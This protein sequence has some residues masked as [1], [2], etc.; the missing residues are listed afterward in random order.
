MSTATRA[1]TAT[2]RERVLWPAAGWTKGDMLDYYA[3]IA[4][5]LLPHLKDRGLTLAR[6]PEGVEGTGWMQADCR[7]HPDWMRVQLVEGKRGQRFRYCLI[8]DVAGLLW[9]A[10]LGTIEF[11]PFLATADRADEPS[12]LVL[13]LDPGPPAGLHEASMVALA[14]RDRLE[15]AGLR[16]VAKTSGSLGLHVYG[17]LAPGHSFA[18]TKAYGRALAARLAS[19]HPDLVLDRVD[20][21]AR[22]GRVYVDWVQNDRNRQMVAAYSL[23]VTEWPSVSTPVAWEEV[24]EAAAGRRLGRRPPLRWRPDEVLERV[25]RL[26]DLFAPALS[27]G[28]VLPPEP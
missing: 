12:W 24:E 18:Q 8:D 23:R 1:I 7:G 19:E 25:S 26:G 9:A 16:T 11:H 22:A 3:A 20:R 5:A 17:P 15:S 21:E 13:D 28:G 2:H 14:V 27:A 6:F 10:N 4:P